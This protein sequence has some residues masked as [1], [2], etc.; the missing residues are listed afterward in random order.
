[1][2]KHAATIGCELGN[3]KGIGQQRWTV[4]SEE[5][6]PPVASDIAAECEATLLPFIEKYS[7][8]D[9][10]LAV[11]T[12]DTKMARLLSPIDD[13]TQRTVVALSEILKMP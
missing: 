6:V 3:L 2:R 7:D 9:T 8:L 1:D 12:T 10:L 5:D 13:K 11:L 4:S